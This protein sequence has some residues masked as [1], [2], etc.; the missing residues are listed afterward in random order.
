MQKEEEEH[1]AVVAAVGQMGVIGRRRTAT[2]TTF[3]YRSG[4]VSQSKGAR[5]P[6]DNYNLPGL[7][8]AN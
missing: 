7:H 3:H 5:R 8:D 6:Q 2:T 4:P 1:G